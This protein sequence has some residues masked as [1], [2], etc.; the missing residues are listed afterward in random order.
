MSKAKC[1]KLDPSRIRPLGDEG[2]QWYKVRVRCREVA[3]WGT[4]MPTRYSC[5]FG[6][7]CMMYIPSLDEPKAVQDMRRVP[8]ASKSML[9]TQVNS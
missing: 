6:I 1:K 5:R 9:L 4:S 7:C 2:G 8:I 3:I